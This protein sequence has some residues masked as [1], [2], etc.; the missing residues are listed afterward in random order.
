VSSLAEMDAAEIADWVPRRLA[1]PREY[2]A[3][4]EMVGL[5]A[6]REAAAQVAVISALEAG[7]CPDCLLQGLGPLGATRASLAALEALHGWIERRGL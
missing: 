2:A 5:R 4:R 6:S 3:W 1:W 7:A